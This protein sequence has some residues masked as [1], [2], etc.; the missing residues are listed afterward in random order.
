[1]PFEEVRDVHVVP[2]RYGTLVSVT[3][4]A[5]TAVL[6]YSD[7][8]GNLRNVRLDDPA[9]RMYEVRLNGTSRLE[10]DARER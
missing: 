8:S 5:K 2:S 4:D 10:V 7:E 6:W 3:G 9:E 1:L